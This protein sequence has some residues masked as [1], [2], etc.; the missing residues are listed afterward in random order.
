[1]RQFPERDW[2][3][4]REL[5]DGLLQQYCNEI[6]D[7]LEPVVKNRG[8]DSHKAYLRLWKVMKRED[9]E[10]S[11]LFDD[12]KRSTAFFK[13]AEW[14]RSGLLTDDE[15]DRFSDETR[16]VVNLLASR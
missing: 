14:R 5:K 6:L 11:A 2:K 9:K 3:I 7:K 13:I 12:L 10:L 16:Q 1:M 15:F 8:D 4:L